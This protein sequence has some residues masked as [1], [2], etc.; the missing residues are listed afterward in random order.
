MKK[1]LVLL[2]IITFIFTSCATSDNY[3]N[4][5]EGIQQSNSE[6]DKNKEQAEENKEV[7]QGENVKDKTIE[8][9]DDDEATIEL[10]IKIK[11][12]PQMLAKVIERLKEFPSYDPNK[13]YTWQVNLM[14][15]DLSSFDLR[16]RLK[17]LMHA[18]FDTDTIWPDTLPE[19]FNP[20]KIMEL[21]KNPGLNIRKLH[22]K[23]ITGKG[24]SIALI[25]YALVVDHV[26]Y[27][28]RLKLYEHIHHDSIAH[29]HG[30]TVTSIAAGKN[31]GIAPE[32]DIYFI[33]TQNYDFVN[34]KL[35][36]NFTYTAEAIDR[37]LKI[38]RFLPEDKKIRVISISQAWN[39]NSEK[40]YEE[41]VE[42]VNRAKEE[43]IF[44]VSCNVF[45]YNSKFHF[46]GLDREPLEDPDDFSSYTILSWDEYLRLVRHTDLFDEFYEKEFD[47]IKE[48]EILLIP[49]YSRTCA[50]ASGSD[51]Y[52]FFR[53]TGWSVGVPYIA[54]LYALAC[55]VKPD[56]TPEEFWHEAYVTGIS[57]EI[58]RGD[59]KYEGR[60]VN[61]TKLMERLEELK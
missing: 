9:K 49:L 28:D 11:P 37:I 2:L 8:N 41:V 14:C 50:N 55:Q 39:P 16:S 13:K 31:I 60:I 3:S 15:Q 40:G 12:S 20:D 26:E 35:L 25:D 18:T 7:N 57:K 17:D 34:G 44:V 33:A 4:D 23:G 42:A 24:V 45:Q 48:K 46:Y 43:G 32:A 29:F 47:K 10:G 56:I 58:K 51:G 5:G 53:E 59:K 36:S 1:I 22:E 19:E 38:N 21:G 61:P 30:P 6:A 52:T 27:K 54:G